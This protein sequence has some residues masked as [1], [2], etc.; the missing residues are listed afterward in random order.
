MDD[1]LVEKKIRIFHFLSYLRN[2]QLT[3]N[4]D[5]G[6]KFHNSKASSMNTI[7]QIFI[8]LRTRWLWIIIQRYYITYEKLQHIQNTKQIQKWLKLSIEW[9]E[10]RIYF[11]YYSLAHTPQNSSVIWN[12]IFHPS[13]GLDSHT[14]K[15]P[16][17][18]T[19]RFERP[20]NA[21][22]GQPLFQPLERVG[23]GG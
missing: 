9:L 19:R 17:R 15:L 4:S 16:A 22:T 20:S 23:G 5:R 6:R 1:V 21:C 10:R 8:F 2:L 13:D 12:S 11:T 18:K 14:R 3:W 7:F